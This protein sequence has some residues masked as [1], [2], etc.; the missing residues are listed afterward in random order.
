MT[1]LRREIM[2]KFVEYFENVGLALANNFT[3]LSE[4]TEET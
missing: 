1:G 4:L 3:M 2:S